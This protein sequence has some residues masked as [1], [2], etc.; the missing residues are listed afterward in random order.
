MG[1][2]PT[3]DWRTLYHAVEAELADVRA[4]RDAVQAMHDQAVAD[5]HHDTRELNDKITV[6][7]AQL[8]ELTELND[9]L[10]MLVPLRDVFY[11]AKS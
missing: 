10:A 7:V 3:P 8:V 1:Y 4:E 2:R 6:L 11:G 5:W 9:R